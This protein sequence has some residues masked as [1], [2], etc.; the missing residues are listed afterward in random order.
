MSGRKN[1]LRKYKMISAASMGANIT[2]AV[3]NIQF[4]DNVSIQLVW[5]GGGTP[6]GTVAVQVSLDY[7][8]DTL[9]NVTNSGT[10][11]DLPLNPTP[12]VSGNSGS[13]YLDLNQLSAPWIRTVYTRTSGS[14]TM[15][16]YISSKMI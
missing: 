5:S 1:N 13:I 15:N 4:C 16:G 2:S 11:S 8:Q 7:A 12:A 6:V 9:G 10:W 14:G 3:T